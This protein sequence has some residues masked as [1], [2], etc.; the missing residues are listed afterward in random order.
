MTFGSMINENIDRFTDFMYM[1]KN[2]EN[3]YILKGEIWEITTN[4]RIACDNMLKLLKSF[5]IYRYL[6]LSHNIPSFQN[7]FTPYYFKSFDN[8]EPHQFSLCYEYFIEAAIKAHKNTSLIS[9]FIECYT[10]DVYNYIDKVSV[11]L[12][13]K[14]DY[15]CETLKKNVNFRYIKDNYRFDELVYKNAVKNKSI[16][17]KKSKA[18][19]ILKQIFYSIENLAISCMFDLFDNLTI[20]FDIELDLILKKFAKEDINTNFVN[21]DR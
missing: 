19:L 20:V 11:V 21:F 7:K 14:L 12:E 6:D 4:A 17:K 2:D 5:I 16:N 1:E 15:M 3:F 13:K 18:K 10:N 9:E 8:K